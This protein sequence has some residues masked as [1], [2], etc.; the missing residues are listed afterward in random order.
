MFSVI[1]LLRYLQYIQ[2][3][4]LF[5]NARRT[6]S[7]SP[8][9]FFSRN[10]C[11]VLNTLKVGYL[12]CLQPAKYCHNLHLFLVAKRASHLLRL[13]F[14]SARHHHD[15]ETC[16]IIHTPYFFCFFVQFGKCLLN[17][18]PGITFTYFMRSSRVDRA[19]SCQCRSPRFD[20]SILRHNGIWEAADE[21]VLNNLIH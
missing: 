8:C 7:E 19:S 13:I 10:I 1:S 14:F 4:S 12:R 16:T 21:A 18:I 17:N 9:N 3:E 2:L 6:F 11:L 5:K 20:P 15:S